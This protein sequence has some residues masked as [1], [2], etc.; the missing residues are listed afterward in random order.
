MSGLMD[1]M[2]F[3]GR[4]EAEEMWDLIILVTEHW[5]YTQLVAQILKFDQS[6]CEFFRAAFINLNTIGIFDWVISAVVGAVL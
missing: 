6:F 4:N 1:Q 2:R 5:Q 3:Y